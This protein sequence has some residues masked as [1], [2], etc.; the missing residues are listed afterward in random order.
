M[1]VQGNCEIPELCFNE[2]ERTSMKEGTI[3]RKNE[4]QFSAFFAAICYVIKI[5]RM[6]EHKVFVSYMSCSVVVSKA[7]LPLINLV[8][9]AEAV[10]FFSLRKRFSFVHFL[11]LKL[12]SM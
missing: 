2:Q 9:N 6:H 11:Y 8:S 10:L 3:K 5:S 7:R 1:F 4:V 12:Y